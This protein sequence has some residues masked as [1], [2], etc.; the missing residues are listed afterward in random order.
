MAI[1][2]PRWKY[3]QQR[4]YDVFGYDE[5][6]DLS[7]DP[8]ENYNVRDRLPEVVACWQPG[9][10]RPGP[11]SRRCD[12]SCRPRPRCSGGK[13]RAYD[14]H[15]YE[16]ARKCSPRTASASRHAIHPRR[17]VYDGISELLTGRAPP[18]ARAGGSIWIDDAPVT[19]SD[20]AVRRRKRL[21]NHR[22]ERA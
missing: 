17:N 3:N 21:P 11:S 10:S 15:R 9:S 5:L 6:Y 18:P 2:T 12:A 14:R 1:R 16:P 19:N 8:A 22:R 4:T 13:G 7:K 20:S